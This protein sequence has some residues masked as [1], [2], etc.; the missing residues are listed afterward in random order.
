MP[1]GT[2]AY[3]TPV[4]VIRAV[5]LTSVMTWTVLGC[6]GRIFPDRGS[7]DAGQSGV[8]LSTNAAAAPPADAAPGPQ[9]SIQAHVQLPVGTLVSALAYKLSGTGGFAR[10]GMQSVPAGATPAF[11]VVGIPAPG[12]YTLDINASSADGSEACTSSALFDIGANKV[13]VVILIAQCSG[14]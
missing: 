11:D 10:S 5:S 1:A 7:D 8:S 9:G 2:R 3:K 4:H 12:R 14:S 13:T 6:G